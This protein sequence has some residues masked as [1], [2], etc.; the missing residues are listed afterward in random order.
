M[1]RISA[2]ILILTALATGLCAQPKGAAPHVIDLSGQWKFSMGATPHNDDEVTLPGSML[3]NDKG[4]DVSLTTPWVGSIYD[5]SYYYNPAMKPYRMKGRLKFP[6]FL[7]PAKHYVGHAWYTKTVSIPRTWRRRR[8]VLFLERPHIETTVYVNGRKVGHEMSL[9]APHEYDLTPFVAF[10]KDNDIAIDVYNGIENVCVG[11]DSH[12]VTDQTQ[13][14]W[15]GIIGRME[16]RS[17]PRMAIS[18]LSTWPSISTSSVDV[19][20]TFSGKGRRIKPSFCLYPNDIAG[21]R[22]VSDSVYTLLLDTVRTWDEYSPT[23]YHLT[24]SYA[25]DTLSTTFGMREISTSG[26]DIMLNGHPIWIRGTVENCDFPLTGYPPTDVAS[27][28]SIF[29][30][31]KDYGLNFMRFHS[32]CPPEAAFIAADSIGVYLQ[33]EGPSWPNHGVKLGKGMPIDNYL[34]QEAQR[35]VQAYGNHPSF[36]MMAAGNEPAGNWVEWCNRFV[37]YWKK[38][39][40]RR[41]YA[42][43]SVGGGWAWDAGSQY[44]VKGGAR[45]LNWNDHAPQAADDYYSE[46]LY[47]RNY[48][49]QQPNRSPIIAHEQGQWCAFPDL[50]E[51]RLYTGPYKAY[52][53]DIFSDLLANNGMKA[54]AKDFL[55][56]SGRLQTL[57]Y[58]YEIERNL[59]TPDYSGFALLGL[60]DYSGQGTALVGVLN[61]FWQEK[62]YV[63]ASEWRQWCAPLVVLARMP[64]FVFTDT[65]TLKVPVD[66]YNASRPYSGLALSYEI[67]SGN[68]VLTG[69]QLGKHDV[70]LGKH[71][72]LAT[73]TQPL[74]ALAAPAKLTLRLTVTGSCGT[75]TNT[76]DFWV[77]PTK[78]PEERFADV[79]ITDT[80]D[81]KARN[82]LR[83]GGKVLI[84]AAGKVSYG[85]DVKQTYLPVFW[86]TSWFKMRPPHT[87]GSYIRASHPVFANF[88]TDDWQNLN[89][90]ELVN[91]AQVMNLSEFPEAFQPIVQPIDTWHVSRKLGMLIEANVLGGRLMM[92]TIDLVKDLDKRPVAKQLLYSVL[93][94]MHSKAFKPAF[95]VLPEVI[96]DLFTKQAPP[97][98]M[99]T[100]ESP[101]ELKPKLTS[102]KAQ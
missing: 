46:I 51:R 34:M 28:I 74:T 15:N 84:T 54:L 80:L 99:Y 23:L 63:Q 14:D 3:T 58:K 8:V 79:Y 67:L 62:G 7:T 102:G 94:Y 61:V 96:S 44:H 95:T 49:G 98:N 91:H 76:Y 50:S 35:M 92:T 75:R 25:D 21:I 4:D 100:K 56:A 19:R 48:K 26:R 20:L 69:G 39:D 68:N 85:A 38:H 9:S 30:K 10:G 87:T 83:K 22:Q 72:T 45:G 77:Y 66:L 53:F 1:K 60:N 57:A 41:I 43:A 89:W 65:D 78:L 97:V 59:R 24:V 52:N 13:G 32:Y 12:S 47:P 82:V 42:G 40:S 11:Q 55:Y 73:I 71:A 81:E 27:W 90:W 37:D 70:T 31:C 5:S 2:F 18:N 86:N 64:R 93:Q 33:P 88:P 29:K 6:F 101:D 16:L 36:C 17:V